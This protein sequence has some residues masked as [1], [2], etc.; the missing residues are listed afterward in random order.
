MISRSH[1]LGGAASSSSRG[2]GNPANDNVTEKNVEKPKR[3]AKQKSIKEQA[4]ALLKKG[5]VKIDEGEGIGSLLRRSGVHLGLYMGAAVV[6]SRF[7][8]ASVCG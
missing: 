8:L 3:T 2:P 5:A 7:K 4:D 1:V 6:R